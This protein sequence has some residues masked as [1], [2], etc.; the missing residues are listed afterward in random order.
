MQAYRV[1][2]GIAFAMIMVL[3]ADN[4]QAQA[5]RY[6]PQRSTVSPYLALSQTN[7]GGLPNY[8]SL[9]RPQLQQNAINSAQG[10]LFI[11]QGQQLD[12][13]SND[14]QTARPPVAPTGTASW[15]MTSGR[16]AKF[17]T[18]GQYYPTVNVGARR[19]R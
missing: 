7:V 16:A 15:F 13:L 14:L 2:A 12:Q 4:V 6:V 17:M 11:Q 18:S 1:T 8:Y 3:H 5:S 10:Q 19:T 9:V